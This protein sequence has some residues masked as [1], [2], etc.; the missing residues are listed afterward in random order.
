MQNILQNLKYRIWYF[1]AGKFF[2]HKFASGVFEYEDYRGRVY[3]FCIASNPGYYGCLCRYADNRK[4]PRDWKFIHIAQRCVKLSLLHP[5][6]MRFAPEYVADAIEPYKE[7]YPQILR[8]LIEGRKI[9]E[10]IKEAKES[11]DL[12]AGIKRE[13][14]EVELK[15]LELQRIEVISRI[16]EFE[17]QIG[18]AFAVIEELRASIE[19]IKPDG[20]AIEPTL[21]RL[22]LRNLAESTALISK[23]KAALR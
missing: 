21:D 20:Y 5:T 4:S 7:A 6:E 12:A 13:F 18:A 17:V 14:Y 3:S 19:F 15:N 2:N 8:L 16:D 10:A 23:I 11:L 9:D 22:D 1:S